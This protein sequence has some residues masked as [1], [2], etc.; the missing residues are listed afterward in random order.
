MS[1]VYACSG[2]F[3]VWS[4]VVIGQRGVFYA[5]RRLT[6]FRITYILI[7]GK[8]DLSEWLTFRVPSNSEM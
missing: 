5:K 2:S 8:L 3:S 7:G 6:E 4:W 1:N